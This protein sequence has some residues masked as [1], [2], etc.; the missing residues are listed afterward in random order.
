M[1]PESQCN[2]PRHTAG[3]SQRGD[4]GQLPTAPQGPFRRSVPQR[5]VPQAAGLQLM[6][7]AVPRAFCSSCGFSFCIS[8]WVPQAAR[9]LLTPRF[10]I[11]NVL[12]TSQ[13][14]PGRA[15]VGMGAPASPV[16]GTFTPKGPP[17]ASSS[18]EGCLLLLGYC[19]AEHRCS[20]YPT[21]VLRGTMPSAT[22]QGVVG[23]AGGC[24]AV[25][26]AETLGQYPGRGRPR[27]RLG[28]WSCPLGPGWC[29]SARKPRSPC[30]LSAL[31]TV[32]GPSPDIYCPGA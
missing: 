27:S 18:S 3:S 26:G 12:E 15:A 23:L 20:R 6:E 28:K 11:N 9:L 13:E 21:G 5:P 7:T 19:Q 25:L 24:R 30:V 32:S 31:R 10:Q 2:R 29:H 17:L 1:G 4:G 8:L 14:S 16:R 22:P